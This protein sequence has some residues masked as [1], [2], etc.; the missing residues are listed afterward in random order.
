M[1]EI[2]FVNGEFL[3]LEQ[4]VVP[5]E[6]RGFQFADA[7]YEVLATYGGRPFELDRHLARLQRSLEALH[8]GYDV[9]AQG[10]ARSILAG[11]ERA[12]F[13]ETLI[14]IQI[15][16]GVAPRGHEFPSGIAPTVV[17]TFKECLRPDERLWKGGVRTTTSEDQRWKRCDIKS[18]SLLPNVLAKQEAAA[19]GA[20]EVLLVDDAGRVTEGA[21][22]SSFCVLGGVLKTAP[23][24]PHILPGI[25]R[26]VILELARGLEIPVREE[27]SP[28]REYLA[29]E[30]VFLCGTATEVMPVVAIDGSII[31]CG[32]PGPLSKRLRSAFLDRT[33]D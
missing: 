11:I 18:V 8:I 5:V 7:V 10:V 20:F 27:F 31:G 6:D 25:T 14:Y 33:G 1:P 17:M 22:T 4:A 30:E 9:A 32:R 19:S 15:S 21:S 28:L 23:P 29:A 24:G 16:R 13:L 26:E 3:R 2:A 12:G